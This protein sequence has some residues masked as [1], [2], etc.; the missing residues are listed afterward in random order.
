MATFE[1][2]AEHILQSAPVAVR[3]L[4]RVAKRKLLRD[5]ID[6]LQR[7]R[8]LKYFARVAGT[9]GFLDLCIS[10]ISELKRAE[11]WP[12]DLVEM[13]E[14]IVERDGESAKAADRKSQE[15]ALIYDAYQRRLQAADGP[16]ASDG[17]TSGLYDA[18]GRFWSA[19][20]LM[21]DG[22]C[23]PYR[24]LT[25]VVVD[26][27][28]DFTHTQYEILDT[29]ARWTD[30]LLVT[31]PGDA[32][33]RDGERR[34]DLF[35]KTNASRAALRNA[36]VAHEVIDIELDLDETAKSTTF[37]HLAA[38]LFDNPRDLVRLETA[39][40][41]AVMSCVRQT[42]E[43][44][45]VA[46]RVKKLLLDGVP[47]EDVVVAFRS[48]EGNGDRARAVFD[49]AGVPTA[50]DCGCSLLAAGTVRF[51]LSVLD[52]ELEDWPFQKLAGILNSALYRP[53]ADFDRE[54]AARC[55][56]AILRAMNLDGGREVIL[57]ALTRRSERSGETIDQTL[58]L[59]KGSLRLLSDEMEVLRHPAP[60]SNWVDRLLVLASNLGLTT[61]LQDATANLDDA[62]AS[63]ETQ[64]WDAFVRLIEE[65]KNAE[66]LCGSAPRTLDLAGFRK[67]LL[68]LL[69]GQTCGE[70]ESQIGRVRVLSADQVRNLDV[71][72]LFV[73]G[74]SE[75][76]FPRSRGDDCLFNDAER[77]RL[78]EQGL[79]LSHRARHSR[80]EMLLFYGVVTRARKSLTLSYP[81]VDDS[82]EPLN[83]SPYVGA[84][85]E[86]FDR[87][88]EVVEVSG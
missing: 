62:V 12:E 2:F 28:T 48:L 75:S 40:G 26:G 81:S 74:M 27:F 65:A 70:P 47:A 58:D 6:E 38:H 76:A 30:R 37:G 86:L 5:L 59:A 63:F 35:T 32:D 15:L 22:H 31:L 50:V 53:S 82:G 55:V 61:A 4:S 13:L 51:L 18:E 64:A 21:N 69:S 44:E 43:L 45:A 16:T 24:D 84:V 39:N 87:H 29:L 17:V 80:E 85:L 42:G 36:F 41:L 33:D 10:F 14:R 56:S 19:R 8:R 9:T 34:C 54:L 1:E 3:P 73:C 7:R 60:F 49:D 20:T 23:G 79:P 66:P 52:L 72:H 25:C 77:H 71:P 67:Q 83:P 57:A 68:E 11:V 88:E 46:K 78:T